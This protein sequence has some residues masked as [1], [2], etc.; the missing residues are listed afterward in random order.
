VANQRP[1]ARAGVHPGPSGSS[2]TSVRPAVGPG[3]GAATETAGAVTVEVT[4]TGGATR[5]RAGPGTARARGAQRAV[6]AASSSGPASDRIDSGWNWTPNRG[7]A[8]CRRA[9]T[10]PSAAHASTTS[11]GPGSV[12]TSEWYRTAWKSCGTPAKSPSPVWVTGPA[13]PC[14]GSAAR[15]TRPPELVASSWWPRHTPSTGR[16]PA[17]AS[18]GTHQP[19]SRA[20]AGEP[21]PG[22]STTPSKPSRSASRKEGSSLA[23]TTGRRPVTATSSSARFQVNESWLSTSSNRGRPR[24]TGGPAI[25]VHL[26][27]SGP[28]TRSGETTRPLPSRPPPRPSRGGPV[29]AVG[30]PARQS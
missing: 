5:Y 19:T 3:G 23:T 11:S 14:T 29:L 15:S 30:S 25:L 18:T 17:A 1:C 21:G 2:R 6:N 22:E 26:A 13:R 7:R 12:T 10:D 24:P 8:R 27:R 16:S 28:R 20:T 9:M 4:G